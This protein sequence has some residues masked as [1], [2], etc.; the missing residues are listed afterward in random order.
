MVA[1]MKLRPLLLTLL[2][3][4]VALAG[5]AQNNGTPQGDG[6]GDK[7]P[8]I[9]SIRVGTDAA[10]PPFEDTVDGAIVG[11]DVEVMQE[12]GN[13]S[14]FTV[15]FQNAVFDTIISS[16]QSG[17]FDAGMS[18][19]SIT[20][21]RKQEVDFSIPYYDNTLMAAIVPGTEGIESP[22][23]LR[24]K[25]VCT[26]RGT[27]S[28]DYLRDE[29]GFQDAD[30]LLLDTAPPCRDA[31]Q[32]GDVAAL[33]IDAAFVRSLIRD[34]E[35]QIEQAFTVDPEEQFGIVVKKGNTEL[36]VAINQALTDMRADGTLQKL[37]DKWQV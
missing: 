1:I 11:F 2:L 20:D 34:S 16:V 6:D 36:L 35:G 30:L 3:A 26:Q 15:G 10:Y 13:R 18:A 8:N 24:G 28:A 27:T 4:S 5:C 7:T 23:D 19:F 12:I 14:G 21:E 33:L 37:Q 25:K 9:Q 32:R 29:L 17:Q 31:L 22:E